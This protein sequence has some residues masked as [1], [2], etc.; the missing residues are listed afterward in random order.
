MSTKRERPAVLQ[1]PVRSAHP[2]VTEPEDWRDRGTHS[3][4]ATPLWFTSKHDHGAYTRFGFGW[5]P[6]EVVRD[7]R[8]EN[9]TRTVK[10]RVTGHDVATV[11]TS[12]DGG[13]VQVTTHEATEDQVVATHHDVELVP[14]DVAMTK[15]LRGLAEVFKADLTAKRRE[16]KYVTRAVIDAID[17]FVELIDQL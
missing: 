2:D 11:R 1:N 13:V 5:G 6:L 16:K 8:T 3:D 10:V 12:D 7:N 14:D 15:K 17:E 4:L 9:G